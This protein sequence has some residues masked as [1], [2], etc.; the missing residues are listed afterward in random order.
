MG[1]RFHYTSTR[2]PPLQITPLQDLSFHKLLL[3]LDPDLKDFV[4]KQVCWGTLLGVVPSFFFPLYESNHQH[5][6]VL[7]W[8]PVSA[9]EMMLDWNRMGRKLLTLSWLAKFTVHLHL[10]A[11][12]LTTAM[13]MKMKRPKWTLLIFNNGWISK[14]ISPERPM[15]FPLDHLQRHHLPCRHHRP[16]RSTEAGFTQLLL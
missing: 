3:M 11:M 5:F 8:F 4:W 7:K 10:W 16:L 15:Q 2:H 9:H 6:W 14:Q 12:S 1:I 13:K